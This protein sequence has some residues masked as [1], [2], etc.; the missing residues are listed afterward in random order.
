M[1]KDELLK[2][3]EHYMLLIQDR[4]LPFE[5][6]AAGLHYD[7]R[8]DVVSLHAGMRRALALTGKLVDEL[9]W[10]NR[11]TEAVRSLADSDGSDWW[12]PCP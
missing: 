4:Q 5:F 2:Q 12:K 3:T 11:M 10:R 8:H 6:E 7:V 9:E 1:T